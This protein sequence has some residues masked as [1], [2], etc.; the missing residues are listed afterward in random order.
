MAHHDR[1][2][3]CVCHVDLQSL[4]SRP[5]GAAGVWSR[6]EQHGTKQI[7]NGAVAFLLLN[8]LHFIEFIPWG[9][10][11]SDLVP[12][13]RTCR[14]QASERGWQRECVKET[15]LLIKPRFK[16]IAHPKLCHVT[17]NIIIFSL[18]W[19]TKWDVW[20]NDQA[21]LLQIM[22]VI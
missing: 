9:P 1:E 11:V 16:A 7:D 17:P 19:N 5:D 22:T 12:G 3:P 8:S 2:S 6:A 20:Q 21:A 13:R 18:L 10:A 14:L 15:G 4:C